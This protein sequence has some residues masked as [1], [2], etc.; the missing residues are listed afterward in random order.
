MNACFLLQNEPTAIWVHILHF[1]RRFLVEIPP[2]CWVTVGQVRNELESSNKKMSA[3]ADIHQCV[4]E[5]PCSFRGQRNVDARGQRKSRCVKS[6]SLSGRLCQPLKSYLEDSRGVG[7]S[8]TSSM[9]MSRRCPSVPVYIEAL[10]GKSE[11]ARATPR[12][13]I[14][15]NCWSGHR[16]QHCRSGTPAG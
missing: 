15:A 8:F 6:A 14:F 12:S 9:M 2:F 1:E 3:K 11:R 4:L 16:E 7:I 5:R 13:L 10:C